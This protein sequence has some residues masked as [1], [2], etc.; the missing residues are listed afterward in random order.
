MATEKALDIIA[1]FTCTFGTA[2]KQTKKRHRVVEFTD[3]EGA[4]VCVVTSLH[5]VTAEEIAGMYKERWEI[6]SFFR[7]IK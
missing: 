4:I 2:Q 3:Y 5:D 1:D 6:E 7:W